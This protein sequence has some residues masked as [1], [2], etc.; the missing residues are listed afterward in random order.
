MHWGAGVCYIYTNMAGKKGKLTN[1]RREAAGIL[2]QGLWILLLLA[3]ASYDAKDTSDWASEAPS[4][5][6]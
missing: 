6:N 5:L 1:V 2:M 3:L 4:S